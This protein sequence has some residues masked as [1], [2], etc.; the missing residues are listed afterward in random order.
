MVSGKEGFFQGSLGH[1]DQFKLARTRGDVE[2]ASPP[3]CEYIILAEF[4]I[5]SGS[6]V[7]H[8]FPEGG[9]PGYKDDFFAEYMLPEGAHNHPLDWTV[10]FLNKHR[11]PLSMAEEAGCILG[12]KVEGVNRTSLKAGKMLGENFEESEEAEEAVKAQA[13][14]DKAEEEGKTGPFLY[15]INLV[16]KKDD[17]T[18]KRGAVVKAMCIC[19]Q[20]NFLEAFRP[21]LIIALDNYYEK[22]D[23]A[24]LS[25]L[26]NT[27]N[28]VSMSS[29][30]YP[31]PWERRLMRRGVAASYVGFP[32]TEHMP[33]MWTHT[34]SFEYGTQKVQ[35][36]LPLH[37]SPDETLVPS[38]SH[39]FQ[40]FGPSAMKIYNAVLIGARILFVGYNHA[41]GDVGKFV[42]AACAMISPP[43]MR[44]VNRAF[45]Y[46]NLSDLTF[47]EVDGYVAGV[48]NP[49]F[50]S[51]ADWWDLLCQL[52]LPNGTGTVLTSEEKQAMDDAKSKRPP[53]PRPP[54]RVCADQLI[55][56]EDAAFSQKLLAGVKASLSEQWV[57][58]MLHDYTSSLINFAVDVMA[59]ESTPAD[60]NLAASN[61]GRLDAMRGGT[62]I[63]ALRTAADPWKSIGLG[64]AEVG[65]PA[66][67]K[68]VRLM[69]REGSMSPAQTLLAFRQLDEALQSEASLQILLC[70][71][72]ESRGGIL[73]LT[74]GLLHAN[75]QIREHALRLMQ[76]IESFD[77]TRPAAKCMN[78][79]FAMSYLRAS[80][81]PITSDQGS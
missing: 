42:L 49:M 15:C 18:V 39:L 38:M 26:Y 30:P 25:D 70:L 41:A 16:R 51:H 52:D 45:P 27:M 28:A 67:R 12:S 65:G 23:P 54:P 36:N 60:L 33:Q 77:S 1:S 81:P 53:P 21:L 75:A 37:M 69:Q 24:I 6:T 74:C 55:Y 63:T 32:P 14:I 8:K 79:Y 7:R 78:D 80:A 73:P 57:R 29:V 76:R 56:E 11:D 31:L 59:G 62:A 34:V 4:D 40:V 2:G 22:Q 3:L 13:A 44:L 19:S 9:V 71:L 20:Y 17:P 35:T 68:W 50:E 61:R 58:S 46:A 10:M 5:D 48:T 43:C 64:T 66:L 72:P 47:L